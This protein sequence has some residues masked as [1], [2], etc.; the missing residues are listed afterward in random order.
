MATTRRVATI[1]GFMLALGSVTAKAVQNK[2]LV[3]DSRSEPRILTG[4]NSYKSMIASNKVV[5]G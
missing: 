2:L 5:P 4:Q 1:V 3:L